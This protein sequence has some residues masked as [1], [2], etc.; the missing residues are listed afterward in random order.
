MTARRGRQQHA[1]AGRHRRG[2]LHLV[3][4]RRL[5]HSL[6]DEKQVF[7]WGANQHGQVGEEAPT[8]G[9]PVP[10]GLEL[11]GLQ[12]VAISAG[13][14]HNC[15]ID[16]E[17]AAHCWGHNLS[18]RGLDVHEQGRPCHGGRSREWCSSP[19][20]PDTRTRAPRRMP[21][22]CSAGG[23]T[24]SGREAA[25]QPPHRSLSRAGRGPSQYP[26]ARSTPAPSPT[27]ARSTAGGPTA[28]DSWLTK[29][30]GRTL[31]GPDARGRSA[32]SLSSGGRTNCVILEDYSVACWGDHIY[33]EDAELRPNFRPLQ[34]P[35]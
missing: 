6:T 34:P 23:T 8:T 27:R 10:V 31:G 26:W 35:Q 7:C 25:S 13:Y 32:I 22:R 15:L 2:T 19:Y 21:A 33:T 12:A 24:A 17:G 4:L 18:A 9:S 20:P 14:N 28:E 30:A 1:P 5:P 16:S 3:C 11:G 29:T